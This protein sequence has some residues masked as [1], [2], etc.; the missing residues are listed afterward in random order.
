MEHKR[1]SKP[2]IVLP[3]IVGTLFGALA[4]SAIGLIFRH[5]PAAPKPVDTAEESQEPRP[6]V[7]AE[8]PA[9]A[10]TRALPR[11][12]TP[13]PPEAQPHSSPRPSRE[14]A[15]ALVSS[16][17]AERVNRHMQDSVD[18]VWSAH[19]EATVGT[20]LAAMAKQ[21]NFTVNKVECRRTSCLADI[22]WTNLGEARRTY[23]DL[24]HGHY[25]DVNCARELLLPDNGDPANPVNAQLVLDH[26]PREP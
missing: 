17:H 11:F 7:R 24:L 25:G 1:K 16:L 4:I 18:P 26:C 3:M 5:K 8:A 23:H 12:P 2:I 21:D 20:T 22:G 19:A 10:S 6:V 15:R 14:E 9:A 13:A